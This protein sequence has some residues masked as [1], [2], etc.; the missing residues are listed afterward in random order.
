[1]TI[2]SKIIIKSFINR[3]FF[4]LTMKTFQLTKQIIYNLFIGKQL[5]FVK[6]KNKFV[7][8]FVT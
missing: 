3:H 7:I 8:L 1:M 4:I 5:V 2:F 6:R